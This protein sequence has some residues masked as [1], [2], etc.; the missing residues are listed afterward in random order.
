MSPAG[1]EDWDLD[2][3]SQGLSELLTSLRC[4]SCGGRTTAYEA[5]AL[6]SPSS[7]SSS[8]VLKTSICGHVLCQEC[9][10]AFAAKNK[11]RAPP[12][13]YLCPGG[14]LPFTKRTPQEDGRAAQI[15]NALGK[16]QRQLR[17]DYPRLRLEQENPARNGAVKA[18]LLS[19]EVEDD[20]DEATPPITSERHFATPP[21]ANL[22]QQ[23][24]HPKK[25]SSSPKT[26]SSGLFEDSSTP[27][28]K[29]SNDSS[30]S[31]NSISPGV[32]G[33]NRH[34]QSRKRTPVRAVI[35]DK[36]NAPYPSS[37]NY[38]KNISPKK[39]MPKKAPSPQKLP[40]S[41]SNTMSSNSFSSS[42]GSIVRSPL[43]TVS[44]NNVGVANSREGGGAPVVQ[45]TPSSSSD[46]EQEKMEET[47]KKKP[48]KKA[49][50]SSDSQQPP[51][52]TA[53]TTLSSKQPLKPASSAFEVAPPRP[54]VQ[55]FQLG[56]LSFGALGPAEQRLRERRLLGLEYS[57]K[58]KQLKNTFISSIEQEMSKIH[59]DSP[60]PQAPKRKKGLVYEEGSEWYNPIPGPSRLR[61]PIDMD[62]EREAARKLEGRRK[63][64]STRT[65]GIGEEEAGSSLDPDSFIDSTQ[66]TPQ[67]G[68]ASTSWLQ[69]SGGT[70]SKKKKKKAS[71]QFS[72][73]SSFAENSEIR[74]IEEKVV[75]EIAADLSS[76]NKTKKPPVN[77]AN[78]K[79]DE[80]V[81]EKSD[82][83]VVL[84]ESNDND[85]EDPL[86]QQSD[87]EEM[88]ENSD[89]DEL[90][91]N[92]NTQDMEKRLALLTSFVRKP[93]D[94]S[95]E[96]EDQKE[97]TEEDEE[98]MINPTP[99][100]EQRNKKAATTPSSASS[101]SGGSSASS[102]KRRILNDHE[103]PTP[104]EG[105]GDGS[106]E[107]LFGSNGGISGNT[108]P[109]PKKQHHQT[110]PHNPTQ[111]QQQLSQST[112]KRPRKTL[113]PARK[114]S[115]VPITE[116]KP[117]SAPDCRN[118][119]VSYTS[120]PAAEIAQLTRL[121]QSHNFRVVRNIP[122]KN[123][124]Q[125]QFTHMVV[126]LDDEG[127][128][129]RTFKYLLGIAE[130][131]NVV[132]A[133]WIR[134][135]MSKGR[136][137]N[138][139][140]YEVGG[141]D[142]PKKSRLALARGEA[143]LFQDYEFALHGKFLDNMKEHLPRLIKILG[144]T[145]VA[146][147]DSL[148]YSTRKTAFILTDAPCEDAE[149]T[150]NKYETA[151]LHRDWV[152]ECI[153]TYSVIGIRDYL[154]HEITDDRLRDLG[155]NSVLLN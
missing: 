98:D 83:D 22:P 114:D 52:K 70:A 15:S 59:E 89:E 27:K 32:S 113:L 137:L 9:T 45:A 29:G 20:D 19:E 124:R 134:G 44:Q 72:T 121:A 3:V 37:T 118:W 149:A 31:S 7:S 1:P 96:E 119:V 4:H 122:E 35:L 90:L 116:T 87:D 127:R 64:R 115:F 110:L 79:D 11:T 57:Q 21:V 33:I 53:K 139:G 123:N 12:G 40:S 54:V 142:G 65:L 150:F 14:M 55:F 125:Q 128:P 154:R 130:G 62:E 6:T 50:S 68:R 76:G 141:E 30:R 144:G 69:S 51:A 84:P 104:E 106:D 24:Q 78:Y 67:Q 112:L 151:V 5:D 74:K 105:D 131:V 129:A 80:E 73:G 28:Q 60:A 136:L 97:E 47:K 140:D 135:C 85:E 91:A 95:K 88:V 100:K 148:S 103:K 147:D 41:Q 92:I 132:A 63:L 17:R 58:A 16:F 143:R 26:I 152:V 61:S 126:G 138:P 101:L 42:G 13:C 146:N 145:V 39:Q 99:S 8:V 111:Q 66:E 77:A 23:I 133:D 49:F 10:N 108:P 2:L 107:D 117:V 93:G 43:K 36:E 81:E 153:A 155:Y 34:K 46:E 86:K 82:E 75:L 25:S 38:N 48:T 56:G 120:V 109:P 18:V 71:L 94:K 102:K